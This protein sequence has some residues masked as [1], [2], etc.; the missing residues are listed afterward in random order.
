MSINIVPLT[1]LSLS[2]DADFSRKNSLAMPLG[3]VQNAQH[4]TV[5]DWQR[6]YV[7]IMHEYHLATHYF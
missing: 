3:L 5:L 6:E 2:P 4:G 1:F 7:N